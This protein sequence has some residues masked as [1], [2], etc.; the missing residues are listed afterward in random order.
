L[1][2]S[3]TL[4]RRPRDRR[5]PTAHSTGEHGTEHA[6]DD[7]QDRR[8]DDPSYRQQPPS[9]PEQQTVHNRRNGDN[10]SAIISG[11]KAAGDE[12][13][14]QMWSGYRCAQYAGHPSGLSGNLSKQHDGDH[15]T[16]IS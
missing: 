7:Q 13:A 10:S 2:A 5:Q 8:D 3:L 4:L 14:E 11:V 15:R 9:R 16:T 1:C 12:R 6:C